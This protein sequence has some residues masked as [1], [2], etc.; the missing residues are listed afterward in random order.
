MTFFPTRD[1]ALAILKDEGCDYAV[2]RHSEA[3]E[4]LALEMGQ[5]I[6]G[7]DLEL[8]SRGALLHDVGRGVTHDIWHVVRSVEILERSEIDDEIIEIVRR[9]VG[10]G[11][12]AEEASR[13]GFPPGQYMPETVEQKVVAHADNLTGNPGSPDAR[14][15]VKEAVVRLRKNG[16]LAASER[17]MKLHN[18]L[19]LLC[20]IDIDEL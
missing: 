5:R 3:V 20:G 17:V 18:E 14:R 9:H 10:A 19:S 15:T 2:I 1:E 16:K 12:T 11:L 13:L 4:S 7:C 8:V 6:E